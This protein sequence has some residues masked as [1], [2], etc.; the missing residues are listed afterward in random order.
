MDI[1]REISDRAQR[2]DT[3]IQEYLPREEGFQK[4]IMEAMN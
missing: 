2:I 1:V 3:I 4:V